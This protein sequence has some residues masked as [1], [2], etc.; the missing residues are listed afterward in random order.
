MTRWSDPYL[1]GPGV[2]RRFGGR[3]RRLEEARARS[4]RCRHRRRR[5]RWREERWLVGQLVQ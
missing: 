4:H 5:H 1:R 3:R 2:L